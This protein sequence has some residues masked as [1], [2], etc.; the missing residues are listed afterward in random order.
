MHMPYIIIM[1]TSAETLI[2]SAAAAV[3]WCRQTHDLDYLTKIQEF[4]MLFAEVMLL[5]ARF[6]L[7][8]DHNAGA[9]MI[10]KVFTWSMTK[11]LCEW[12]HNLRQF[13]ADGIMTSIFLYTCSV[14]QC[15]TWHHK[16]PSSW[17]HLHLFMV[18]TK[19]WQPLS[20]AVMIIEMFLTDHDDFVFWSSVWQVCHFRVL[21]ADQK[22]QTIWGVV[23]YLNDDNMKYP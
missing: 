8:M 12:Q 6:F 11:K 18:C 21:D 22:S 15:G 9:L 14:M 23:K 5:S 17:L 16:N 7:Q 1:S 2:L 4:M 10:M 13:S 3:L 19:L 20:D